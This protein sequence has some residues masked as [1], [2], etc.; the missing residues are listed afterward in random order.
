MNK[1]AE[2]FTLDYFKYLFGCAKLSLILAICSVFFG[3]LF[4]TLLAA[5]KISRNKFLRGFA[6][7]YIDIIRGTPMLLQ[8]M[9]FYFGL[10]QLVPG[11]G[12]MAFSTQVLITGIIGMSFNSSAYS[13]ELIRSG[14]E[15]IDKGQWEAALSLG[16]SR[17]KAMTLIILPQAFKRIIPPMVS[18]FITLIKDSSLLSSFGAVELLMGAKTI[19]AKYYSYIIP[20]CMAGLIYL[21]MTSVVSF[22]SRK[23]ERKLNEN[24]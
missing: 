14:I 5:C 2:I 17:R 22:L 24:D 8:L 3:T 13:A 21:L 7:V 19:G 20:L 10:P 6:T 16:L 11:Y 1:F 9:L 15:S 23:L 12:N 18:E 4:G